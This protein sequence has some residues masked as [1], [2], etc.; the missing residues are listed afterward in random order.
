MIRDATVTSWTID[1]LPPTNMDLQTNISQG[2]S[3][4]CLHKVPS[5]K[6][7]E[8]TLLVLRENEE[9]NKELFLDHAPK[10]KEVLWK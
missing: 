6:G 7:I 8:V 9:E 1:G 3:G 2:S 10:Q 5:A 4:R